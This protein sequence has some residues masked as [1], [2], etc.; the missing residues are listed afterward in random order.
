[1]HSNDLFRVSSHGAAQTCI[2]Y[3]R[4]WNFVTRLSIK[5]LNRFLCFNIQNS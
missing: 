4:C 3:F 1:M 2:V 5:D